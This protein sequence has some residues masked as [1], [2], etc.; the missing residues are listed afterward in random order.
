MKNILLIPALMLSLQLLHAQSTDETNSNS[1][2]TVFPNPSDG[3]FQVIYSS[4]TT[5]P[6]DGWGG[7]LVINITN[8]NFKTVYTETIVDFDGEYNKTIDLSEEEGDVYL[9]EVVAG[10]QKKSKRQRLN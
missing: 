6:P 10:K 5:S 9:I 8:S 7:V 4:N 1:V 3:A 2:L